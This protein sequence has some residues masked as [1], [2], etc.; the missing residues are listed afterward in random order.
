MFKILVRVYTH[1]VQLGQFI[2][3]SQ[4][5]VFSLSNC[6][7]SVAHKDCDKTTVLIFFKHISLKHQ[8]GFGQFK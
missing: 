7:R 6:Q 4:C 3:M 5:Q 1:V 2:V 8:T